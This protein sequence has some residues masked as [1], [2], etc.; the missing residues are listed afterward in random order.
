MTSF[1]V[2]RWGGGWI[3]QD[4]TFVAMEAQNKS[5]L[6]TGDIKDTESSHLGVTQYL[7]VPFRANFWKIQPL[8]V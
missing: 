4:K 2:V 6:I 1:M 7:V 5:T 3:D 8:K